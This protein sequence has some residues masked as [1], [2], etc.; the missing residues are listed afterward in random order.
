MIELIL[1]TGMDVH[2][3]TGEMLDF[4]RD[5]AKTI[6]FS[7]LYGTGIRALSKALNCSMEK[8]KYFKSNA[9]NQAT[10]NQ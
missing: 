7:L 6:N 10:D 5:Q 4:T 1:K 9:T 3:A 8:G 2:T